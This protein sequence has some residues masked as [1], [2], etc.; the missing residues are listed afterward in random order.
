ME[1]KSFAATLGLG[2]VAGAA[3]VLMLPKQSKAYRKANNV[4]QMLKE[5]VS[6]AVNSLS[7][8]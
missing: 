1:I 6:Q 7:K 5:E 8:Q 4:A 3:A 2:M